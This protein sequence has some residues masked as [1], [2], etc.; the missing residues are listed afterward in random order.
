MGQSD[1]QDGETNDAG[2]EGLAWE[3]G[4]LERTTHEQLGNARNASEAGN[5]TTDESRSG[6]MHQS[7]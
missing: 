4:Q 6:A 5:E 2:E 1:S 7:D 3:L